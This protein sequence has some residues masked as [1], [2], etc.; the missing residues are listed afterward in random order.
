MLHDIIC[1]IVRFFFFRCLKSKGVE[2][3]YSCAD[4]G[5]DCMFSGMCRWPGSVTDGFGDDSEDANGM[6]QGL[7][8]VRADNHDNSEQSTA[9]I[10]F[11]RTQ[12]GSA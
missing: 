3:F 4:C 10:D 8:P 11:R 12:P 9:A 5:F 2:S 7:E 6:S 1:L